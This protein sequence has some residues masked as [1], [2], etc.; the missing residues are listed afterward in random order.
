MSVSNFKNGKHLLFF[1]DFY[2]FIFI[3][4]ETPWGIADLTAS[5]ASDANDGNA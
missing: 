1:K 4:F 3:K 5:T 2:R